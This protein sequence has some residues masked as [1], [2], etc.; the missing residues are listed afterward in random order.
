MQAKKYLFQILF[1]ILYS[2]YSHL[3]LTTVN[4]MVNP[5]TFKCGWYLWD[6]YQYI[7]SG[8]GNDALTGLDV[9]LTRKIFTNLSEKVFYEPV[10]WHQHLLDLKNGVRD[11]AAGATYSPDRAEYAY[12]SKPYRFEEDS[13]FI[14][15][16]ETNQFDF[17][18]VEEMLA[19]FDKSDLRVGVINGYVFVHP[20]INAWLNDPRNKSK[21]VPVVD[22]T[23]NV[24]NLTTKK[25]DCFIA[26]RIVGA[27]IIWRQNKGQE[28]NEV[29]IQAKTPIHFMFSK[30][31]V[32]YAFVETFNQGITKLLQS[33]EYSNIVTW[34]FHPVLLLQTIDTD[35]FRLIDYLGT[36]AFA[37]SGLVIAY[38]D[39]STL[40][41]AFIFALL[42]SLGGGIIRDIIFGRNPI[43]A[44]QSPVYLLIVIITVLCGYAVL[45]LSKYFF[46]NNQ[47][48]NFVH[49]ENKSIQYLLVICDALGLAAFTVSGI[50][51]SVLAK[52]SPLWLWGA[53]F[54][55]LTGAGGGILRDMLSR[56]R[57][58]TSINGSSPYAEVSI[59]WGF[60]LA[61]FLEI[62]SQTI[63]PEL[64]RYAVI[65][66][67]AGA[68]ITRVLVYAFDVPNISF[69]VQSQRHNKD[70]KISQK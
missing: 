53:F 32:P 66:T 33:D 8:Q 48:E 47:L 1:V 69:G 67:V 55:F 60:F 29:K 37:I 17:S 36:V 13:V 23:V 62:Q 2:F 19:I 39:R 40:F 20:K 16:G 57:F 18:T 50:I 15:R 51:V 9:Q 30:K 49:S 44:L 22:D 46:H 26:D 21:I 41:G 52:V 59:V 58:I 6:P 28:I 42:P 14:R 11:V 35:W 56:D 27:T 63:D 10:S 3:G 34:Y 45:R 65:T 12:F 4:P 25:I 54:S 31:T 64:I 24:D 70:Q 61:I 68:F 5:S 43:G 38:R 7:P